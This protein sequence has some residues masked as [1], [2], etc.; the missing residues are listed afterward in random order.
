MEKIGIDTPPQELNLRER[1]LTNKANW[2]AFSNYIS[3]P[4]PND[5]NSIEEAVDC[6]TAAIL[7]A[8]TGSIPK[9]STRK[10]SKEVPWWNENVRE[11]VSARKRALNQFRQYPTEADLITFKRTRAQAELIMEKA[12]KKFVGGLCL[13]FD[14]RYSYI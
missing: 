1:W 13:I 14:S 12:K 5:F 4:Y 2:D 10:T 8:A 6:I 11:T 9:S 7:L 3:L